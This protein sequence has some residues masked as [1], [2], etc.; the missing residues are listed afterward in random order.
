MTEILEKCN[1]GWKDYWWFI[2]IF[3]PYVIREEI[4]IKTVLLTHPPQMRS[5]FNLIDWNV[6]MFD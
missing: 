6:I 1:M 5:V 4:S 3:Y 2:F